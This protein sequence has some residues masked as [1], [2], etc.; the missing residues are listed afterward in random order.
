[1]SISFQPNF[2]RRD[3]SVPLRLVAGGM[4]FGVIATI[5]DGP[6]AN[7]LV[8]VLAFLL[9]G[10]GLMAVTLIGT[11]SERML[12]GAGAGSLAAWL[13]YRFAIDDRLIPALDDGAGTLVDRHLIAAIIVGGSVLAMGLGGMLEAL[14]AQSEPGQA[15]ITIRVVLIAIGMFIAAIVCIYG[16]VSTGIAILVV[17]AAGVALGALAWLRAERPPEDFQPAP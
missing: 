5:A 10:G 1:M 8:A 14:R 16:G 17:I 4:A 9:L 11:R 7:R 2:I 3:S 15:P 6:V 13:G 12:V